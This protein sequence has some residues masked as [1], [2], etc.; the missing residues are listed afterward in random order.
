MLASIM[1]SNTR[2]RLGAKADHENS[3]AGRRV[4]KETHPF[5]RPAED[6][7]VEA[8]RLGKL[9]ALEDTDRVDDAQPSVEFATWGVVEVHTLSKGL[10]TARRGIPSTNV[11][12]GNYS[13]APSIKRASYHLL[14]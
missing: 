14:I 2:E 1:S 5:N 3:T 12:N 13:G 6:G 9:A 11:D 10:I 4:V 8:F 7:R